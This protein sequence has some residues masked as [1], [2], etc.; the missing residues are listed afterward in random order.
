VPARHIYIYTL[1]ARIDIYREKKNCVYTAC[2]L[3]AYCQITSAQ[4]Y[5]CWTSLY[6]EYHRWLWIWTWVASLLAETIYSRRL[7]PCVER[8]K[9]INA[10][11]SAGRAG[12]NTYMCDIGDRRYL[13]YLRYFVFD[14][15]PLD[16][17]L[18][19]RRNCNGF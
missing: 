11:V 19:S 13:R 4:F 14:S 15:Y 10:Q 1:S 16:T 17:K 8:R 5:P 6:V 12:Y 3:R 9:T 18:F 2:I 7:V